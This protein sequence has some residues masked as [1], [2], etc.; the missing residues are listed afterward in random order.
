VVVV[1][2]LMLFPPR[3]APTSTVPVGFSAAFV[4][5]IAVSMTPIIVTLAP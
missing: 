4:A 5:G 2:G 1:T 3:E